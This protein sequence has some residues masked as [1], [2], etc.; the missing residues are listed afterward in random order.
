MI[1]RTPVLASLL[2][3]AALPCAAQSPAP[4]AETAAAPPPA[5]DSAPPAPAASSAAT[6]AKDASSATD[7][8]A[9]P[10]PELLKEAR[11]EGFKPKKRNGVTMFCYSDASL[12]THLESEKCFDQHHM[13][14]LVQQR[15]DQRNLLRQTS[16]C[17]GS[18]CNGH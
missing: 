16:A 2:L 5:A 4:A 12:G 7:D 9:A 18:S 8:A 17:T 14:M 1:H 15:E 3:L 6:G 11:R 10:S 13:E